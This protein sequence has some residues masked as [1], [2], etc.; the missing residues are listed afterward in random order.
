MKNFVLTRTEKIAF[1]LLGLTFL[2]GIYFANTDEEFFVSVYVKEDG[3]V[4][5]GTAFFLLCSSILMFSRFFKQFKQHK[6][7]HVRGAC[8]NAIRKI[9]NEPVR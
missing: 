2:G 3:V 5:Y 4:E 6:D 7:Y 9:K 8:K 1:I